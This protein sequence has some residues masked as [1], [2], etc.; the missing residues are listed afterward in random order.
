VRT[1]V[2]LDA[3][4]QVAIEQLQVH[5]IEEEQTQEW[6]GTRLLLEHARVLHLQPSHTLGALLKRNAYSL[7]DWVH[8]SKPEDLCFLAADGRAILASISHEGEAYMELTL[9]E[10][11]DLSLK[12][13]RLKFS[14]SSGN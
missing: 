11:E 6:P 12:I 10:I 8:P 7:F 4:A 14:P 13:E 3:D 9:E 5:L 1:T 2:P